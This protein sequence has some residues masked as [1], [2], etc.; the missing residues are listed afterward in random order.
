M[1]TGA[2][3]KTVKKK[4]EK[5]EETLSLEEQ[6]LYL[7][8]QVEAL[9]LQLIKADN[10]STHSEVMVRDLRSKLV[11]LHKDFEEEKKRTYALTA[12]MTRQYKRKVEEMMREKALEEE[13]RMKL[14]DELA[15]LQSA[16]SAQ[17]RE[18]AQK[19]SLKEA[20][21]LEQKQKMDEMAAEFGAMLRATLEK[22]SEKIEITSDW[23]TNGL[24]EPIVR[25]FEDFSL[26][27]K[28]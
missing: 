20:E 2:K 23:E 17:E 10:Q 9:K 1:S 19:L 24:N 11:E 6:N 28:Q 3:K 26:A 13:R 15:A 21:I 7:Q 18:W 5:D 22:M 14:E 4:G 16:K 27:N 12:D 8:R 25:T